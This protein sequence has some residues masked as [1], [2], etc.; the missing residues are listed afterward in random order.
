MTAATY[1]DMYRRT[2]AAIEA[3]RDAALDLLGPSAP[4]GP[5]RW[6]PSY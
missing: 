5:G 1:E 2:A 3:E 6:S 4:R